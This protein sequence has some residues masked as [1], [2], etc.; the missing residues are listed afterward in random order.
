MRTNLGT[1]VLH[2]LFV[3]ALP[4]ATSTWALQDPGEGEGEAGGRNREAQAEGG[5]APAA[6]PE[7]LY[8]A[9]RRE[10]TLR[11]YC[12][13]GEVDEERL[14]EALM[15]I[16]DVDTLLLYGPE[17]H[18]AK[19]YK[20]FIVMETGA[21]VEGRDLERALK[22]SRCKVER[23]EY[24]VLSWNPQELP[25]GG[26][27][28]NGRSAGAGLVQRRSIEMHSAMRWCETRG[29]EIVFYYVEGKISPEELV[30]RFVGMFTS[31]AIEASALEI[32]LAQDSLAWEL[33]SE[34]E[35]RA[36]DIRKLER[37]IGRMNGVSFVSLEPTT[38]VLN[39][40]LT[41]S[42]LDMS[43]PPG[44]LGGAGAQGGGTPAGSETRPCWYTNP[45]LDLLEDSD[46]SLAAPEQELEADD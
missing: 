34:E 19:P 6:E 5:E 25:R 45:L 26:R 41:L 43:G 37:D 40:T 8:P 31:A 22:R 2:A 17:Q 16:D 15:G 4:F 12:L 35:L 24:L 21:G 29:T 28:N 7:Q 44:T 33:T 1:L 10:T 27:R 46:L 9:A 32:Q 38:L 18:E 20:N 23:L 39:V 11:Y 42:G 30:D 14:D 3:L 36:S 13:D